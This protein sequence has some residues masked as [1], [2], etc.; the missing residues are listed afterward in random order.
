[1]GSRSLAAP[2][3]RP[4][5]EAKALTAAT[6]VL[7]REGPPLAGS[8]SPMVM[9]ALLEPDPV[10]GVPPII[11]AVQQAGGSDGDGQ[12]WF[13]RYLEVSL[14]PLIRLLVRHGIALEAHT[15]NSLVVLDDGR[16]ARFVVRDLEGVSLNHHHPRAADRF[17]GAVAADSPALYDETE[18]W[19]RFTYYVVVNHVGQL[20][21]T[22]AEYGGLSEAEL[23]SVAG[24]VLS[25]EAMRH[26]AAPA[27]AP[28]RHLLDRAE[29]PA[30]ANLRSLL[31]G[32]SEHPAW[33]GIPN[34]LRPRPGR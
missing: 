7:Y 20:V 23:W 18:V 13:G 27:A 21:A 4:A 30:K 24:D 11:R 22:L 9:A 17:G 31:G 15:Q 29:L 3:G 1:M 28:L 12:A 19:Q 10:D 33:T 25:D 26:G 34:P 5:P 16:P 32:H 2:A 14:R 8:A 6:G